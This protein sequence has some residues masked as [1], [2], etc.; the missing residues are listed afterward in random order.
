MIS[1]FSFITFLCYVSNVHHVYELDDLDKQLDV[2]K[3]CIMRKSQVWKKH[4][5]LD[6]SIAKGIKAVKFD[7][8][9]YNN[10]TKT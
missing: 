2:T 8:D 3:F 5:D 1:F 10:I 6:Q 4:R 9:L 7:F